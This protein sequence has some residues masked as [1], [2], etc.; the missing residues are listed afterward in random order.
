MKV[1]LIGYYGFG[2]FGDEL[3]CKAF[4]ENIKA[5][6]VVVFSNTELLDDHDGRVKYYK[7]TRRNRIF[8]LR[9]VDK[10][11]WGGGT[12]FYSNP[13]FLSLF[14]NFIF[15]RLI[16]RKE[17]YFIGVGQGNFKSWL[18]KICY[19]LILK[20]SNGIYFRDKYS[21]HAAGKNNRSMRLT[22]D[23][24]YLLDFENDIQKRTS[25]TK[26]SVNLLGDINNNKLIDFYVAQIK[27]ILHDDKDLIINLLPAQTGSNGEYM[28]LN[29]IKRKLNSPRVKLLN[30]Q[31]PEDVLDYLTKMDF[32]FGMRLHLAVFSDLYNI[33]NI[34]INY[35]PK[36]KYYLKSCGQ[37]ERL[38]DVYELINFSMITSVFKN[39]QRPE[40]YIKK[41]KEIINKT[42]AN[43]L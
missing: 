42:L 24:V 26:I 22:A 34:A 31:Q 16:L 17:F 21:L 28:F 43:I 10:V 32:H 20:L 13:G 27:S 37:D 41:Q 2:N 1:A 25:I 35:S 18:H 19:K 38:K 40:S 14:F 11:I 12:C 3:M 33:P 15:I 30:P 36:I 8:E 29:V 4:S 7:P 5:N 6:K 23:P 9:N 39:Y